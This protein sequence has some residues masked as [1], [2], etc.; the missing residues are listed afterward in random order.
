MYF[1]LRMIRS[2][3]QDSSLARDLDLDMLDCLD[4]QTLV[5]RSEHV[6]D[7]LTNIAHNLKTLIEGKMVVP[8]GILS[9][10][11]ES[12]EL[13]FDSYDMAFQSFLEKNVEQVDEI[14][15]AQS[16]I[17]RLGELITPIPYSGD[18]K[19]KATACPICAIRESIK[20]ISEY[21]ADIAELTIDRVYKK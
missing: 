18:I 17:I 13:A 8:P 5:H 12:A 3:S 16:E 4:V 2:A 15:D 21:S 7:H 10:L 19:E 1:I 14:I 11:I 20:R 6:A 9:I